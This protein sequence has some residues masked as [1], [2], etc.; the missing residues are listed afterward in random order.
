MVPYIV[1]SRWELREHDFGLNYPRCIPSTI[2]L[3]FCSQSF[4]LLA[5]T[6]KNQNSA[7]SGGLK[8]L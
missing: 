8:C 2:I 5:L 3:P 6:A 7:D 4:K 1:E